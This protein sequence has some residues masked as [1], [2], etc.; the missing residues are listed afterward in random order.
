[1]GKQGSL[2]AHVKTT[3]FGTWSI[4]LS[5][6][7]RWAA[8]VTPL[9]VPW[10]DGSKVMLGEGASSRYVPSACP[11]CSGCSWVW[12]A[13]GSGRMMAC[14]EWSGQWTFM[15]TFNINNTEYIFV[16]VCDLALDYISRCTWPFKLQV[17]TQLAHG[18]LHDLFRP[19]WLSSALSWLAKKCGNYWLLATLATLIFHDTSGN[20]GFSFLANQLTN[21]PFW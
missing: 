17:A 15:A 14:W 9:S 19:V 20:S 16:V 3:V 12:Q 2:W 5:S 4:W 13:I 1:M 6:G 10:A 18:D 21:T 11:S 8:S 7:K